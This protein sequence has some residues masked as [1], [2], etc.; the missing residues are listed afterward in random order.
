MGSHWLLF[1]WEPSDLIY[2]LKRS[3]WLFLEKQLVGGKS[4]RKQGDR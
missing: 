1:K 3:F 4:G 2:I